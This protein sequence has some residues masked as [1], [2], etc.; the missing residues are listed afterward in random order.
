M[1]IVIYQKSTNLEHQQKILKNLYNTLNNKGFKVVYWEKDKFLEAD[2]SVIFGSWKKTIK[3]KKN[4]IYP[5]EQKHHILKQKIIRGQGLKPIVVIETPLLCRTITQKHEQYRFGLYHFM[6]KLADFKNVNSKPDRF[7]KLNLKIKPWRKSTDDS[8]ILITTQNLNDASLFGI[9]YTWWLENTIR[10]LLKKTNRKIIVR[11]H[12]E[13]KSKLSEYLN[14]TFMIHTKQVEYQ[15]TGT[16][17][18][19]L[20]NT[21][22]M[23]TY[24]S[25]S[26]I[27]AILEGIPVISSSEYSFVWDISSHTL[28]DIENPKCG[29][30]EQLLYDL[31]YSQWSIEEIENGTAWQHLISQ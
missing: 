25:G 3:E 1:K 11:D 4:K 13:N 26:S 29:N 22:C 17:Q 18:E 21:H 7:N 8:H 15:N 27:D 9:H 20:K 2:I 31:A 5:E 24:S 10:H 12:P 14:N 16:I 19:A 23:V 6:S 30:R 28:N